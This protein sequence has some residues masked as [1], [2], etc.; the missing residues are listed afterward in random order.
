MTQT[1]DDYLQ[2]IINFNFYTD[3]TLL[4]NVLESMLEKKAG[5]TFAPFG[6]FKLL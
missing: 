2:Q 4:Q 6:K 5:K 3:S 1:G